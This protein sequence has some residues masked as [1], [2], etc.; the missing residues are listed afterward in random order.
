MIRTTRSVCSLTARTYHFQQVLH[1]RT[2]ETVLAL[3]SSA[4]H[5]AADISFHTN[6]H[7]LMISGDYGNV[8]S[9]N[10]YLE[11]QRY[12]VWQGRLQYH[13]QQLGFNAMAQ[14]NP[15]YLIQEPHPGQQGS[16]RQ[17]TM[18]PYLRFTAFNNRLEL[19]ASDHLNYYGYYEQGW[20]NTAQG[21][22]SYRFKDTWQ[23][24]AQLM[25][26][27]FQRYPNY[28]FLQTQVSL[29]RSFLRK[30]APGSTR[31]SVVF[32]G[33]L[34]ANGI[35]DSD[36][37]PVPQVIAALGQSLAQS[38][39]KGK[40]SFTNLKPADYKL[41]VPNGNGWW[42]LHPVDIPLTRHR[43]LEIALVKAA[44][45]SGYVTAQTSSY[46]ADPPSLEGISIIAT[47]PSGQQFTTLTDAN[48][49]FSFNLP[50]IRFTFSADTGADAQTILNQPQTI[51]VSEAHNPPVYFQLAD[52]SRKVDIKQ[53]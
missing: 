2:L 15:F 30:N 40:V 48:G 6:G 46:A 12:A 43:S 29:S 53:F 24:S 19:E 26:N 37:K 34:N 39:Q 36:E 27:S 42:L 45:V 33:D 13:Y 31:L 17:Y 32:F 1:Q 25:Y 21:K 23:A 49:A 9:T 50:A 28:N 14:W 22:I 18:G 47:S 51:Q 20:S 7:G 5:A 52:H 8:K 3:R 35:W 10:P 44:L 16:F 11:R 38:N 4:W 41:K